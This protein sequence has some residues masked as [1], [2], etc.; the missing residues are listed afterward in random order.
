VA[1]WL[2]HCAANQKV[3]GSIS[4]GVIGI[5]HLQSFRL[6]YDIWADSAC[7]RNEHRG[8]ILGVKGGRCVGQTAYADCLEIFERLPPTFLRACPK[9]AVLC[10]GPVFLHKYLICEQGAEKDFWP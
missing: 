4:D 5:F 1:Q 9:I 8:Y 2:R 10:F 6:H 3:A 7:N